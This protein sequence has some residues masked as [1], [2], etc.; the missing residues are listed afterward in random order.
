MNSFCDRVYQLYGFIFWYLLL[1]TIIHKTWQALINIYIYIY[2]LLN[3]YDIFQNLCPF[4][5]L[6]KN[7][8]VNPFQ[9]FFT[10]MEVFFNEI[11]KCSPTEKQCSCFSLPIFLR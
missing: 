7:Q 2:D 4:L 9:L 1:K 10:F 11:F 5:K 6:K 3:E 8:V